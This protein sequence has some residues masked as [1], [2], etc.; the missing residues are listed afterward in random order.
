[1]KGEARA[2][3]LCVLRIRSELPSEWPRSSAGRGRVNSLKA[4]RAGPM[5][6]VWGVSVGGCDDVVVGSSLSLLRRTDSRAC[7]PQAFW[8]T[9]EAKKRDSE[10][11]WSKVPS[12]GWDGSLLLGSLVGYLKRKMTP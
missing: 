10:A 4:R 7:V 5:S 6:M 1:M 8:M 12:S 2:K 9:W 11:A 3:E